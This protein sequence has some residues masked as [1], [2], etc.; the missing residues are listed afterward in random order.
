MSFYTDY[1]YSY[2]SFYLFFRLFSLHRCFVSFEFLNFKTHQFSNL[3]ASDNQLGLSIVP[4]LSPL[5]SLNQTVK[6]LL[7]L[8]SA[9]IP[10]AKFNLC[11]F[12]DCRM[13][14]LDPVMMRM[15]GSKGHDGRQPGD[16][17]MSSLWVWYSIYPLDK[18]AELSAHETVRKIGDSVC[19]WLR[20]CGA[21]LALKRRIFRCMSMTRWV[22][23]AYHCYVLSTIGQVVPLSLSSRLM[24]CYSCKDQEGDGNSCNRCGLLTLSIINSSPSISQLWRSEGSGVL[25]LGEKYRIFAR[26][27]RPKIW[28]CIT[29]DVYRAQHYG[30]KHCRQHRFT[31]VLTLSHMR[32][33]I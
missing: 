18:A 22:P 11:F 32:Y 4:P 16:T 12:V 21:G 31:V 8:N 15:Q 30:I 3:L 19:F 26:K 13:R 27:G 7:M 20:R 29:N 25:L 33:Q 17:C 14:M 10:L 6:L 23:V 28:D 5:S 1:L 24:I 2:F 9:L